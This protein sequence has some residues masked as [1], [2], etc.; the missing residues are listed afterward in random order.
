MGSSFEGMGHTDAQHCQVLP[1]A[2]LCGRTSSL[3]AVLPGPPKFPRALSS[4]GENQHPGPPGVSALAW[5]LLGIDGCPSGTSDGSTV[6]L[7]CQKT[8]RT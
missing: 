8:A 2:V 6:I 5:L 7:L 1:T 4:V 3:P